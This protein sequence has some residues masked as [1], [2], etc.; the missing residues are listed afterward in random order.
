[1]LEAAVNTTVSTMGVWV[2]VVVASL[3]LAF[4]LIMI[5]LADRSQVRASGPTPSGAWAVR[6]IVEESVPP[7]EAPTRTDLPA[8]PGPAGAGDMPRQRTGE[9]DRAAR[10][11]VGPDRPD[12]EDPGR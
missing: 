6:R 3:A 2:I 11:Y 5:F 7:G 10:S 9:A 12:E 4:W 8:Q 1:V